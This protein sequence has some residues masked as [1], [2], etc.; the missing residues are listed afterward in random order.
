MEVLERNRIILR[1]N[2]AIFAIMTTMIIGIV[3][4]IAYM[5]TGSS[6]TIP[7]IYLSAG[8]IGIS[9]F[10]LNVYLDDVINFLIK[11]AFTSMTKRFIMAITA[12]ILA[13]ILVVDI[14]MH[15]T[16]YLL[17]KEN[18]TISLIIAGVLLSSS[19]YIG[20]KFFDKTESK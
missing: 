9:M 5:T 8:A 11:S 19:G 4:T 10:I 20:Y 13:K 18:P 7:T 1:Y 15:P 14:L 12:V 3:Q 16:M 2:K 6:Q 17:I